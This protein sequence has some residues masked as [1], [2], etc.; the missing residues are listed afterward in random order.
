MSESPPHPPPPHLSVVFRAGAML[1][2]IFCQDCG[3]VVSITSLVWCGM[4]MVVV[5]LGVRGE[6]TVHVVG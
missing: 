3:S 1:S 5:L 2:E 6:V 4:V